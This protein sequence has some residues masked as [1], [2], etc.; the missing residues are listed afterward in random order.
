[1]YMNRNLHRV[2][3][4]AVA[5]AG[6]AA[7]PVPTFGT[8]LSCTAASFSAVADSQGNINVNCTS[9]GSTGGTCSISASPSSLPSSGGTVTVSVNCGANTSL[10]GGKAA[11]ASGTNQ[12]TDTIPANTLST[13]VTYTYTVT[14]DGGSKSASVVEAGTGSTPPPPPGGAIACSGFSKTHVIDVNWSGSTGNVR[15]LTKDYGGFGSNEIVVARFTT[16]ASSAPNVYAQIKAGQWIDA[17]TARTAALSQ[18]PCDFPS[19]NPLGRLA[20]TSGW[21]VISPSV[22]YAI[23]GSSS[24]YAILQPS[25]TY[26]FNIKNEVSGASTCSGSCNM[27][28]ELAKPNGL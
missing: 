20:T 7:V 19:P 27:F 13:G 3:A 10:T 22:T 9:P 26:Y 12:W 24:F 28:I 6:F 2:L 16:P 11:T 18:T 14:G 1:M 5:S 4:A 8:T 15:V 17:D 25:T 23:G 21:G